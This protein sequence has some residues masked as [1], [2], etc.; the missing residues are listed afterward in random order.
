M[1]LLQVNKAEYMANTSCG[2][3]GRGGNVR[4]HTYQLVFTDRLTDQPT[5]GWTDKASYRVACPQLK[6]N[7]IQYTQRTVY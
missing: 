1:Y 2:R 6:T 4:F 3:L 7:Q 5:N